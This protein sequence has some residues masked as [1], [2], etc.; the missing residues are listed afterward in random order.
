MEGF[1]ARGV[2]RDLEVSFSRKDGQRVYVQHLLEGKADMLFEMLEAGGHVYVCGDAKHMAP[3]VRAA[4]AKI[5]AEGKKLPL[6]EGPGLVEKL[7][8]E[9]RYLEDVWASG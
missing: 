8:A 9:K 5:L 4:F 7:V 1:K 6:A 3:D 2:L